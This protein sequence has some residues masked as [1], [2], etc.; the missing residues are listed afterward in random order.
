MIAAGAALHGAIAGGQMARETLV[1]ESGE[2]RHTFD[3]EVARTPQEKAHGLMY[4]TTLPAGTGMLFPYE[5]AAE[6][7]MWMRN[8]Y[9]PLDMVFIRADGSIHRIEA[10]TE[11]MSEEIISSHGDVTGVLEIGAGEAA[12]LGLKPGDVV[13][14]AHFGTAGASR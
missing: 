11:P 1:I 9:I 5:G 2:A 8:T 6:I 7:Q 12:R 3:I 10:H 13:H 14:H 4:R